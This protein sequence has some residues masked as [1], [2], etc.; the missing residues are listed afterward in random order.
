MGVYFIVFI[1]SF[2]SWS[3]YRYFDFLNSKLLFLSAI[4]IDYYFY[5]SAPVCLSRIEIEG[6]F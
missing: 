4:N 3:R 6:T 2:D 5:C 1:S